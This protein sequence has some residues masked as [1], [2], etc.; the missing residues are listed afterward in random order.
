M[1]RIQLE[2]LKKDSQELG[3]FIS[4]QKKKG[5]EDRAY[6]LAKKQQFLDNTIAEY[7]R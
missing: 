4:K 2:R 3:H 5:N 6:K 7:T 1:T